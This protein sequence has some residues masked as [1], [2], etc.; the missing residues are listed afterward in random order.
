MD[1]G[2]LVSLYT[3]RPP[4]PNEP[5][6][7]N[8]I[9]ESEQIDNRLPGEGPSS[10]VFLD[11]YLIDRFEATSEQFQGYLSSTGLPVQAQLGE[12]GIPVVNVNWFEA[13]D[14]CEWAGKRLPTEA[15]WEKAG[16]GTDGRKYPWG[17]AFFATAL[18]WQDNTRIG[19]NGDQDGFAELAPVGSYR[20]FLSPYG[21]EDLAGNAQEWVWDTFSIGHDPN[22]N[23]NPTGPPEEAREV[24]V[25]KGSSW[26]NRAFEAHLSNRLPNLA[27]LRSNVLGF[28]CAR[29]ADDLAELTRGT[30][31]SPSSWGQLKLGKP[32][33]GPR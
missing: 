27:S 19:D 22:D 15:E 26:G 4:D 29:D 21:V 6:D 24:H 20:R 10:T 23:Y 2:L 9:P 16:R 31:I 13:R 28:R 33:P 7:I 8:V 25:V 12:P 5:I 32:G 1:I 14:Y 18:N 3:G 30:A 11:G 17:N